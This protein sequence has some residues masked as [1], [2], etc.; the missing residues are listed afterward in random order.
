MYWLVSL[1]VFYETLFPVHDVMVCILLAMC[2][3]HVLHVGSVLPCL[4]AF[5][6]IKCCV[7]F[8][9]PRDPVK[10]FSPM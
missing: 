7:M 2:N 1:W 9:V 4:K 3:S 8:S 6:G 5:G 10:T